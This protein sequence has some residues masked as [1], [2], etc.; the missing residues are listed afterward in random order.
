MIIVTNGAILIFC[1]FDCFFFMFLLD[2]IGINSN[3]P[4]S[5]CIRTHSLFNT[6]KSVIARLDRAIQLRQFGNQ[7]SSE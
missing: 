5:H 1:F 2:I 6:I 7:V 3:L 4:Q